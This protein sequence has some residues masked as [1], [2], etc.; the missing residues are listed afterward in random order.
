VSVN[1][2]IVPALRGLLR[3]G[4]THVSSGA[5]AMNIATLL[6]IGSLPPF[7]DSFMR[8]LAFSRCDG[9]HQPKRLGCSVDEVVTVSDT[10]DRLLCYANNE[11]TKQRHARML[12]WAREKAKKAK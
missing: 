5:L 4:I 8:E 2:M 7:E 1:A 11:T 3:C 10:N 12:A 6:G 9:W